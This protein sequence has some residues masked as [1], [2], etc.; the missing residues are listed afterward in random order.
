MVRAEDDQ[1]NL[2]ITF[3]SFVFLSLANNP[4]GGLLLPGPYYK[5]AA[6]GVAAFSG[7]YINKAGQGYT[8]KAFGL[9]SGGDFIL[10]EGPAFEVRKQQ[11]DLAI[12]LTDNPDPVNVGAA[13]SY[14][15]AVTNNGPHVAQAVSVSL[16]LPNGFALQSASGSGWSCSQAGN[17]LTCNRTDLPSGQSSQILV[18]GTAPAQAGSITATASVSLSQAMDDPNSA[19]NQATATTTVVELPPTGPSHFLYLPL[20]FKS[21]A[22]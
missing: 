12:T 18:Q 17:T 11:A 8:L 19:N 5:K 15:V 16:L 22:P 3:E 7:L 2:A 20:V 10:V 4:A 21:G 9:G 1:G 6:D 13:L 14:T